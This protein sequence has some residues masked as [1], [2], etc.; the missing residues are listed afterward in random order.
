MAAGDD[1][2]QIPPDSTG[3]KV[4]VSKVTTASGDVERQRAVLGDNV[5]PLA[6]VK[7]TNAQPAASDYGLATRPIPGAPQSITKDTTHTNPLSEILIN[8]NGSG[9]TPIINGIGGKIIKIWKL[10]FQ[11]NGNTDITPKDGGT[12]LSGP[13][14]LEQGGSWLW[15]LDGEPWFTCIVGQTFNLSSTAAVQVS[16]RAYYTQI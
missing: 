15:A 8:F 9:D 3:K 7:V 14:T 5:D 1:F 16:G 4:D 10:W 2:V 13:L 6:L 11:V 12:S